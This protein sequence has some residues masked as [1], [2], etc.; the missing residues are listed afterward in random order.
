M[1]YFETVFTLMCDVSFN[2]APNKIHNL[3]TRSSNVH[4]HN[5]RFS[6][7]GKFHVKKSLYW[8]RN[9]IAELFT[10]C[11]TGVRYRKDRSIDEF[12]ISSLLGVEDDYID[13]H[14]LISKLKTYNDSSLYFLIPL[15]NSPLCA[16]TFLYIYYWLVLNILI[17]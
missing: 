1:L 2:S 8:L 11:R 3:F 10:S 9:K 13:A 16:S 4:P 7:V 17:I 15:I 12:I 14:S 5:T 6:V